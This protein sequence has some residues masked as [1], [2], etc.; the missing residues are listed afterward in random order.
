MEIIHC[1]TASA[2]SHALHNTKRTTQYKMRCT[3]QIGQKCGKMK[4]AGRCAYNYFT[5]DTKREKNVERML[6][7]R[8]L[9]HFHQ[10]S[11]RNTKI[12]FKW[13]D[14][15]DDNDNDRTLIMCSDSSSCLRPPW[16]IKAGQV[17]TSKMITCQSRCDDRDHIMMIVTIL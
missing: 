12:C 14:N 3:I 11:Q 9:F 16:L 17:C 6:D 5:N 7:V 10:F 1:S 15:D 4:N 2:G 13:H 8:Q